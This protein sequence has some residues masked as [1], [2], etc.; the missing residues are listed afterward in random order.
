[1]KVDFISN[2][3]CAAKTNNAALEE[4]TNCLF[5]YGKKIS[6]SIMIKYGIYNLTI[7]D[8]EDYI[9][10]LINYVYTTYVPDKH[11]TFYEFTIFVMQKRL[12][13]KIIELC[14][15]L[16][17]QCQSLDEDFLDGNTFHDLIEDNSCLSIPEQVSMDEIHLKMSSPLATDDLFE[18]RKKKVYM[19]QSAGYSSTEIMKKLRL[20]EGQYRYIKNAIKKDL[21]SF[22]NKIE[23]K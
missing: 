8:L 3:F 12:T 22:T 19:L 11:K 21:K 9:L 17:L 10:F 13:S 16:S 5:N 1:M 20:T 14:K 7:E 2:L 15:Q 18:T 4:L 6:K 23:V